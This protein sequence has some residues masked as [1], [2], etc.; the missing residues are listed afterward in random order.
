[1]HPVQELIN[2]LGI[3]FSVQRPNE[4]SYERNSFSTQSITIELRQ[5]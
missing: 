1:M 4:Y 2:T 5:H 3:N